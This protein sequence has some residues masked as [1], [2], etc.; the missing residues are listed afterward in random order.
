MRRTLS[1]G[2][3]C[4]LPRRELE[5]KMKSVN[6]EVRGRTTFLSDSHYSAEPLLR[7]RADVFKTL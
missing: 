6:T 7:K 4:E 2:R 3:I 5:G 1:D